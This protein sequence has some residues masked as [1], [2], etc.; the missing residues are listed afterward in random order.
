MRNRARARCEARSG[1]WLEAREQ[2]QPCCHVGVRRYGQLP[3]TTR[4]DRVR[5]WRQARALHCRRRFVGAI[6]GERD[7]GESNGRNGSS[8]RPESESLSDVISIRSAEEARHSVSVLTEWADNDE[9]RLRRAI[10]AATGAANRAQALTKRRTRPLSEKEKKEMI[11]VAQTYRSCAE[12]A[13]QKLA[14]LG[15]GAAQ[16]AGAAARPGEGEERSSSRRSTRPWPRSSP[17]VLPRR[18]ERLGASS[19]NGPTTIRT[20]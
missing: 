19:A 17:S 8:R 1:R 18:Q 4:P 11:R 10:R 3:S 5:G 14:R 13:S 7:M 2:R 20:G 6:E 12:R 16:G 9:G 15:G